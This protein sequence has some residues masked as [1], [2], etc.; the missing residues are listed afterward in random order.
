MSSPE[1]AE[2]EN[3][4]KEPLLRQPDWTIKADHG[5]HAD[6]NRGQHIQLVHCMC[7]Y[8]TLFINN[9]YSTINTTPRGK[10]YGR[11]NWKNAENISVGPWV[12]KTKFDS[13]LWNGCGSTRLQ[14]CPLYIFGNKATDGTYG[15]KYWF[16]GFGFD[17]GPNLQPCSSELKNKTKSYRLCP[18]RF[19]GKPVPTQISCS[20]QTQT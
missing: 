17:S 7:V 3:E 18:G 9:M 4:A 12:Q 8:T 5:R 1:A 11:L 15:S 6:V 14:I 2:A 16:P 19:F 20:N 13:I 10:I